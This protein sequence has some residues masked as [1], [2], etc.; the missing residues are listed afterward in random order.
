VSHLAYKE[1]TSLREQGM[2]LDKELDAQDK[3]VSIL[4]TEID[5]NNQRIQNVQGLLSS[6][7]EALIKT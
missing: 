6:K 2:G 4:G 3:R 5:N 1:L 7:E